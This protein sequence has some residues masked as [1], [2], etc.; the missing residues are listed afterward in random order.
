[1]AD[2][3]LVL[4]KV[5]LLSPLGSSFGRVTHAIYLMV[6]KTCSLMF[7]N[8]FFC[9]LKI[10]FSGSR[11]CRNHQQ[12]VFLMFISH[13][14]RIRNVHFLCLSLLVYIGRLHL[15]K[16]PTT[17]RPLQYNKNKT[18]NMT[19]ASKHLKNKSATVSDALNKRYCYLHNTSGLDEVSSTSVVTFGSTLKHKP[20]PEIHKSPP[21]RPLCLFGRTS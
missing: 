3:G 9:T 11:S 4:G 15:R 1:M 6:Q 5:V 18:Y 21:K 12:Y 7:L 14:Q 20:H 10:H 13:G 16:R 19:K 2:L 17:R 8:V